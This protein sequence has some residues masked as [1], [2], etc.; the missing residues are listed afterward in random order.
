MTSLFLK[1]LDVEFL[2]SFGI[3]GYMLIFKDLV[4]GDE[5]VLIND[6]NFCN[7]LVIDTVKKI[8]TI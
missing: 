1:G 3:H 8:R 4:T 7:Q 5:F 2:G 6:I